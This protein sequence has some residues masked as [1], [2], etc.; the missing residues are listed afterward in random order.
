MVATMVKVTVPPFEATVTGIPVGEPWPDVGD[1]QVEPAP[2]VQAQVAVVASSSGGS[3]S[4]KVP[5]PVAPLTGFRIVT[6]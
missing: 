4:L 3:G 1:P 6:V 5:T 2:A